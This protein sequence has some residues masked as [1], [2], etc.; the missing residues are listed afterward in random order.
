M[1]KYKPIFDP[2]TRKPIEFVV[3][4]K[5]LINVLPTGKCHKWNVH[6]LSDFVLPDLPEWYEE[7]KCKRDKPRKDKPGI[8]ITGTKAGISQMMLRRMEFLC[9]LQEHGYDMGYREKMCFLYWNFALQAGMSEDDAKMAVIRF[10]NRF[11][12]PLVEKDMLS[13]SKPRKLYYYKMQT[14]LM[15]LGVPE[16]LSEKYDFD[17]LSKNDYQKEYMRKYRKWEKIKRYSACDTKQQVM[18]KSAVQAK[19]LRDAGMKIKQIAIELG[20]SESTVKR[21]IARA[22]NMK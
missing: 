1:L 7:Y 10:N 4:D 8:H 17:I 2:E 15:E 6:E 18:D 11:V 9:V 21:Y 16:H 20:V 5:F 13:H 3:K 14:V 22:N 12:H 19:E